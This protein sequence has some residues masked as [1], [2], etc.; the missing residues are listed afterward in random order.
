MFRSSMTLDTPQRV[1]TV[2]A[3]TLLPTGLLVTFVTGSRVGLGVFTFVL[4]VL[5]VAWALSPRGILVAGGEL[6]IERRA[7]APL[8][9]PLSSISGA[10]L[11]DRL[12]PGTLR[13]FGVGGFFGSYG[14]FSNPA[15]GRFRLYATRSRPAVLL[16]RNG[17][18]L[19]IVITPDDAAG[20]I[21]ALEHRD[22]RPR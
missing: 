11:L 7:W 5:G 1:S 9:I 4:L 17:G 13:L 19:P 3:S 16:S 21:G 15:L 2:I 12:G 6:Q 18:D 8:C 14:L 22:Q 10:S 20:T